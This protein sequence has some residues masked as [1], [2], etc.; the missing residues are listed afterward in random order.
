MAALGAGSRDYNNFEAILANKLLTSLW[1]RLNFKS[2]NRS[3]VLLIMYD[4]EGRSF[5]EI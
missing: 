2:L 4:M 3:N 1:N 5:I